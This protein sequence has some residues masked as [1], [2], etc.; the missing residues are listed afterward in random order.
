MQM[1]VIVDASGKVIAAH[2]S[3]PGAAPRKP[4]WTDG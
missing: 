2:R 1:T 3:A 4:G